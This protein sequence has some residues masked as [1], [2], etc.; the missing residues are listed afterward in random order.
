MS[1]RVNIIG[2]LSFKTPDE[3]AR[4]QSAIP[5][6]YENLDAYLK[7]EY[8]FEKVGDFDYD[9]DE[10]YVPYNEQDTELSLLLSDNKI[11]AEMTLEFN[12]EDQNCWRSVYRNGVFNTE[13]HTYISDMTSNDIIKSLSDDQKNDILTELSS[14]KYA[15]YRSAYIM[16]GK[17]A[18]LTVLSNNELVKRLMTDNNLSADSLIGY[19][20]SE[21]IARSW[22]NTKEIKVYLS[23]KNNDDYDRY[24]CFVSLHCMRAVPIMMDESGIVITD[25]IHPDISRSELFP[26]T[27]HILKIW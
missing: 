9:L 3:Y 16:N 22:L 12:G 27:D 11:N 17:R 13:N 19:A 4:L 1:Y 5:A 20:D 23:Q 21:A 10:S 6:E 15:L 26:P 24:D 2:S 7:S 18:E 8:G 25:S 14:N